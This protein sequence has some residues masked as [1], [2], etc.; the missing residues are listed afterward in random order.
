MKAFSLR[1]G[2]LAAA[3][4]VGSVSASP[5]STQNGLPPRDIPLSR[6]YRLKVVDFGPSFINGRYLSIGADGCVGVYSGPKGPAQAAEFSFVPTRS[7]DGPGSN[8]FQLHRYPVGI[9]DHAL[10]L[11]GSPGLLSLTDFANPA[12]NA[13]EAAARGAANRSD[14]DGPGDYRVDWTSFTLLNDVSGAATG[15][16]NG[17]SGGPP[18][19]PSS[20]FHPGGTSKPGN[21]SDPGNFGGSGD[22]EDPEDPEDPGDAGDDAD[23]NATSAPG[24]SVAT[25][26]PLPKPLLTNTLS[27]GKS[28]GHWVAMQTGLGVY[29]IEWYD[30]VSFI[31]EN[32]RRVSIVY[33][34]VKS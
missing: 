2:F 30:G 5:I 31:T 22:S 10:A 29:N 16:S 28:R 32:Y 6:I 3:L 8:Q 20:P 25:T 26:N 14:S 21:S 23:D 34:L 9:I 15:G 18:A 13:A 17:K 7:S 11:V 19:P 1:A 27:Y 12:A 24:K 4:A 33:E